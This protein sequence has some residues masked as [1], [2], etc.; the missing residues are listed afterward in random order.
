MRVIVV[1]V[2][3]VV[4]KMLGTRIFVGE[5]FEKREREDERK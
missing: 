2:V 1:V 4:K 3:V 5:S